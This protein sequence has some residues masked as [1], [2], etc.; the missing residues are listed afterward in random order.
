VILTTRYRI[1]EQHT[2]V[3]RNTRYLSSNPV[4][5][6]S[7]LLLLLSIEPEYRAFYRLHVRYSNIPCIP[8]AEAIHKVNDFN[9]TAMCHLRNSDKVGI[10]CSTRTWEKQSLAYHKHIVDAVNN[11][12]RVFGAELHIPEAVS[13]P[14]SASPSRLPI[15]QPDENSPEP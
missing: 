9:L 1:P 8:I 13:T 10:Q 5:S 15:S 11:K 14:A 4:R 7:L 2:C 12:I 3:G 6:K